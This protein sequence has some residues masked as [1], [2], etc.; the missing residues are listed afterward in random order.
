MKIALL[1]VGVHLQEGGIGAEHVPRDLRL[2]TIV[3]SVDREQHEA[4]VAAL[5]AASPKTAIET[6]WVA[7]Q[8]LALDQAVAE[9]LALADKLMNSLDA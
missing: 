7:G 9:A 4:T 8:A 1:G 2:A 5:Q 6:A 3:E